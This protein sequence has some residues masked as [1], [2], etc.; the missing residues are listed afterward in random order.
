MWLGIAFLSMVDVT[1][2]PVKWPMTLEN[3]L[4]SHYLSKVQKKSEYKNCMFLLN[5][6]SF[7]SEGGEAMR[8]GLTIY[9]YIS[10]F[11]HIYSFRELGSGNMVEP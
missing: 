5:L 7:F 1:Y 2:V 10:R 4:I 8:G 9:R 11:L 6:C 3:L